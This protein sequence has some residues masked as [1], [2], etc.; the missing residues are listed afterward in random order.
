[1][2]HK[3]CKHQDFQ[4]PGSQWIHAKCDIYKGFG[5]VV[6][7]CNFVSMYC[8]IHTHLCIRHRVQTSY[9]EFRMG[10]SW[11][12]YVVC[13][14]CSIFVPKSKVHNIGNNYHLLKIES[15]WHWEKLKSAQIKD[16]ISS[17]YKSENNIFCFCFLFFLAWFNFWFKIQITITWCYLSKDFQRH[18]QC[19]TLDFLKPWSLTPNQSMFQHVCPRHEYFLT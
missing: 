12:H 6:C 5:N 2:G 7:S 18:F 1:M 19:W 8:Q 3:Q 16:A 11:S 9:V 15:A 13:K 4:R 10:W 17:T 14:I